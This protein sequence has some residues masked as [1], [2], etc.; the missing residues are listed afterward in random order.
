M[1]RVFMPLNVQIPFPMDL[2]GCALQ[3]RP[4]G[5]S[6]KEAAERGRKINSLFRESGCYNDFDTITYS[7]EM[8]SEKEEYKNH[9]KDRA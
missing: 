3:D 6:E 1:H 8:I 2:T 5:P 7:L 4:S 9:E